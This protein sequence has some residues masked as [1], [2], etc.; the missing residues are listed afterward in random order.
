MSVDLSAFQGKNRLLFSIPLQPRQGSRFQP[1]GFPNLGAATFKTAQGEN[2]LVESAQSMANRLELT[3]WDAGRDAP[4][5]ELDGISYVEVKDSQNRFL[6]STILEAH[7]LNSVYV[8]EAEG[9]LHARLAVEM[10]H[11]DKKPIN[12]AAFLRTLFKYDVNSLIHGAFLESIGGR[13]RVARA[14]S[15]FIEA[16][17]VRVAPSGG[18]KNDRVA[19]KKDEGADAS[20]GYGNVPFSRDEYTADSITLYVSLD[21][22]QIQGYGLDEQATQYLILLSLFKLRSL[23]DGDLRLRT[24][25]DFMV[26]IERIKSANIDWTLPNLDALQSDLISAHQSIKDRMIRSAVVF[27]GPKKKAKKENNKAKDSEDTDNDGNP[28]G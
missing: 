5:Q 14:L 21:L 19:A 20:G 22:S 16:E 7:R 15:A 11:D 17:G 1:T 6:T 18:V 2:L 28:E 13:L 8:E 23:I 12:R 4:L 25:C 26:G 24:A 27:N 9:D 10:E 3:I